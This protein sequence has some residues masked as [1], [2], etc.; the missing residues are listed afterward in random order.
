ML[1]RWPLC[2]CGKELLALLGTLLCATPRK[3]N[4]RI[5]RLKDTFKPRSDI[6]FVTRSFLVIFFF[7]FLGVAWRE[8]IVLQKK[9]TSQ[10][11]DRST[12]LG[13][14]FVSALKVKNGGNGCRSKCDTDSSG[15]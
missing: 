14:H 7:R 8:T 5:S 3:G 15:T 6:S 13:K 10:G 1:N 9:A 12:A 11:I 2:R 4:D